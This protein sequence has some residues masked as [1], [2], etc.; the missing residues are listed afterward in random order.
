MPDFEFWVSGT[1]LWGAIEFIFVVGLAVMSI[2]SLGPIA[3]RFAAWLAV[4]VVGIH[5]YTLAQN[6][7]DKAKPDRDYAYLIPG[8][9]VAPDFICLA[10]VST[11]TMRNVRIAVR[12]IGPNG[13]PEAVYI[14]SNGINGV[15]VDEGTNLSQVM[16]P[17]GNYAIDIDPPTKFG[18]IDERINFTN[19]LRVFTIQAVRKAGREILIPAPKKI[20]STYI[21]GREQ[22]L[23]H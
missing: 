9:L 13:E 3:F 1:A 18:K 10:T 14:Y 6:E 11:G 4:V 20:S 2:Q 19:D 23:S 7:A 22:F 15:T 21:V 8:M 16:L 5:L 17:V 12:R